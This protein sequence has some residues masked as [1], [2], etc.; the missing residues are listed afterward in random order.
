ML[1]SARIVITDLANLPTALRAREQATEAVRIFLIDGRGPEAEVA[2]GSDRAAR[3]M[4]SP[5]WIRPPT[6]RPF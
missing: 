6:T 4:P 2:A 5:M 1:V 3:A